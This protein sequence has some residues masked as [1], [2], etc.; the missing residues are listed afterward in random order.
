MLRFRL[1]LNKFEE[2]RLIKDSKKA[3]VEELENLEA[4]GKPKSFQEVRTALS[5]QYFITK[6]Y[7]AR[8]F[9]QRNTRM[10]ERK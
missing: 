5:S 4:K 3:T 9:E 7:T 1:S 8:K 10:I 2:K 6:R